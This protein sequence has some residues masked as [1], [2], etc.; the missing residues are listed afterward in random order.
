MNATVAAMAELCCER[1]ETM[2]ACRSCG[3]QTLDLFLSQQA[4]KALRNGTIVP[5][6]DPGDFLETAARFTAERLGERAGE[7]VKKA[8]GLKALCS[9][10]HLGAL[11]C[12]QSFQGDLLFA[13]LLQKLHTKTRYV[14]VFC[15]GQVELENSTYAR[16]ISAYQSGDE[17]QLFPIFP[18]KHSVQMASCSDAIGPD[19]LARF[20][21]MAAEKTDNP[22]LLGALEQLGPG[23]YGNEELQSYARFSDQVTLAGE[24]LSHELF[25]GESGPV[26]VYLEAEELVRPLL[27]EELRDEASLISRML[28]EAELREKLTRTKTPDGASL[29]DLLFKGADEKGRKIALTLTPDGDLSGTDWHHERVTYSCRRSVLLPL[30]EERKVLPGVFTNALITF[31]ERGLT[32]FGGPFQSV[33]L[34]GWQRSFVQFLRECGM[35]ETAELFGAY[36]CS[37]YISGPMFA[38]FRGRDFAATAGPVE[39]FLTRPPYERIRSLIQETTLWDAHIIGLSE[40]Y[41]DLVLRNEREENWYRLIAE[42]LYR[43][44]PKYMLELSS[45]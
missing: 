2:R 20:R 32:W 31:F 13:E 35:D 38:L 16:G 34:P 39:F 24:K 25:E 23:L 12:S 8:L 14:P 44:D 33:Y 10:D 19:M 41:F 26:F 18:A 4:E 22:V 9:A 36:D 27:I 3:G 7:E 37:G 29:S 5:A 6:R 15:G 30:L 40:M 42:E 21:K 11:F 17:K 45:F 1:N 43:W 28:D